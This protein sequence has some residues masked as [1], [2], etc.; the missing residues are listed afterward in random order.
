MEFVYLVSFLCV[1]LCLQSMLDHFVYY[2]CLAISLRIGGRGIVFYDLV[3]FAHLL[4]F[5]VVKKGAIVSYDDTQD[6]EPL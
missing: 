6:P 5:L 1:Q 3:L 4:E 2:F